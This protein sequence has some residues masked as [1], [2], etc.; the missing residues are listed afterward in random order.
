MFFVEAVEMHNLVQS[1]MAESP[2]GHRSNIQ[3]SGEE[4]VTLALS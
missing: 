2:S 1:A 3:P 4:G